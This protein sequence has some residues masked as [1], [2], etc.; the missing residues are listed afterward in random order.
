[1]EDKN[2]SKALDIVSRLI[3]GE[4]IGRDV[5]E[6]S[7]LYDEYATNGEVYDIT[8]SICKKLNLSLY[9]YEYSLYVSAGE[10]NRVFGYSNDELKKE[11]GVKL[12]RELFLCYFIIYNV[13]TWFYHDTG[14]YTFN[15]YVKI[16]D[17][18]HSVDSSLSSVIKELSV[19]SLNEVEENSFK[20]IALIWEDLP[21]VSGEETNARAARGSRYGF[22]KMTLNF[23]I[24][25]ELMIENEGRYYPKKRLKGLTKN[26]FEEY[27]G[28]LYEIMK[29]D[30]LDAAHKQNQGK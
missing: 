5:K 16:E 26:Y 23:L 10:N 15:E 6:S 4:E 14:S 8:N 27:K 25:Q 29:G 17:L 12:N 9:E 1:M 7:S 2:L 19:Y 11:I 3:T 21:V 24:N 30:T 18:I 22:V 13:I 28:R 20:T